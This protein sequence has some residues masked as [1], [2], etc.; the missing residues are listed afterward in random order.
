MMKGMRSMPSGIE[1]TDPMTLASAGVSLMFVALA[2]AAVP[3][4]RA[5]R[6]DP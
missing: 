6:V 5:K 1:P 3:A 2:A 4:L